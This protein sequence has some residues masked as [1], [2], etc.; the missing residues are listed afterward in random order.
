M[1]STIKITILDSPSPKFSKPLYKN[2][3]NAVCQNQWLACDPWVDNTFW[4]FRASFEIQHLRR[5][6]RWS[7][8]QRQLVEVSD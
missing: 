7:A 1:F 6:W 3:P 4:A 2:K 5:L 8:D